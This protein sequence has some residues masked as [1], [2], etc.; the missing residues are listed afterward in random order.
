[1]RIYTFSIIV[2]MYDDLYF[3][4]NTENNGYRLFLM[5]TIC[6][7]DLGRRHARLSCLD[8]PD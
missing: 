1:M 6:Y 7:C 4:N 8:K 5:I 2:A 3:Q